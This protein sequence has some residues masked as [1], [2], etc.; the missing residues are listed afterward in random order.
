VRHRLALVLLLVAAVADATPLTDAIQQLEDRLLQLER[1]AGTP[2]PAGPQGIR[3]E[4]GVTGTPGLGLPGPPGPQGPKGEPG[5]PGAVG[6]QG[7]G[8]TGATGPVGPA[9][10]TGATGATGAVGPAGPS[11]LPVI[12]PPVVPPVIIDPIPPVTPPAAGAL[13]PEIAALKDNA[14]RLLTLTSRS[15]RQCHGYFVDAADTVN[16]APQSRVQSG[17]QLGVY[18]GRSTLF[19]FGGAHGVHPCNDVELFDVGSATWTQASAPETAVTAIMKMPADATGNTVTL[20]K[21]LPGVV[22]QSLLWDQQLDVNYR[23]LAYDPATGVATLDQA[24]TGAPPR[25]GT[26]WMGPVAGGVYYMFHGATAVTA[27]SGAPYA[28][29]NQDDYK[30]DPIH[31]RYVGIARAGTFAFSLAARTWELLA[32]PT[33]PTN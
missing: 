13:N 29:H 17:I 24:L 28:E 32:G 6:P 9:G 27:P 18:K 22:G 31:E 25:V 2:G 19:Y 5:A 11:G 4:R 26:L 33:H 20:L 16:R 23:V 14:W 30:Y 12:V 8:P 15:S 1:A 7:G 10:P 3:G 21:G